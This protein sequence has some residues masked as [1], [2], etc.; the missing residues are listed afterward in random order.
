MAIDTSLKF[1]TSSVSA[2][3]LVVTNSIKGINIDEIS[4][5]DS[6][7]FISSNIISSN[8]IRLRHIARNLRRREQ[9]GRLPQVDYGLAKLGDVLNVGDVAIELV[10]HFPQTA[11]INLSH[12]SIGHILN[13]DL[14]PGYPGQ[15]WCDA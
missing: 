13:T 10:S 6:S 5:L 12:R 4:G 9:Q 15:P 2:A 1:L 3:V 7:L 11:G 14:D 8:I